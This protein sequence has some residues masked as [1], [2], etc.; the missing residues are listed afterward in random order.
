MIYFMDK[1]SIDSPD[2]KPGPATYFVQQ[3]AEVLSNFN[4]DMENGLSSETAKQLL[5]KNGPNEL[6]ANVTPKWVMFLRQFNNVI[7]YILLFAAAMTLLLQHYSDAIV[8]GLVVIINAFI[9]YFQEVNASNALEKIKSLLSTEATVIRDGNRTDIPAS[10]LVVGDIVYLEAGDNVPADLRLLDGDN[11]RIQESALTG[12]ADS[13]LKTFEPLTDNK[14][15]LA[16][17]TNMAY[18]STAVTNGSATG[19]VVQTGHDTELGQI[20]SDVS[21]VKAAKTPLMQ[22]LDGLGKWISYFIIAIAIILF[23]IGWWT[24]IYSLPILALAVVTM[25]VGSLPEGLPASTSVILAMGVNKMAKH[26]A[27]VKTLPAVETLGTVDVIAT[28]KTGTLTKNE[29]TAQDIIT[30]DHRY[31]VTGTGY[32]PEGQ[33]LLNQEAVKIAEDSTLQKLLVAG[34]EANDTMLQ[35]EDGQWIINGEPTDG[36]FLTLYH[37]GFG[38]DQ[39]ELTELDRIPF[40]SDYR[41]IARLDE[42]ADGQHEVFIKG[43]PDKLYQMALAADP[44]FDLKEWDDIIAELTHQGKR[45]VAVGHKLVDSD[46]D[47]VTH[48][49]LRQGVDFLGIVGIIDPPREEVISALKEMHTA[50]VEV[51]MITGD[52][53][54]TA[55]A[56]GRQLGLAD[57]I[58]TI[59]GAELDKMSPEELK[60]NI[61][62][63]NVFARTTPRNKLAIID[64][65]Q[66]NGKITAMTGDGVNDAPALKKADI[67][68][69]MGIKGT[70][71]AKDAADMILVDD[72]FTTMTKAIREGR[73]L[74]ANIKKTIV[75]LLPTSFAEGLIVAFSILMQQ[76]LPLVPTQL[77]WINM[78]SAITIQFAFIFEPEE[79]GIMQRP[80]RKTGTSLLN[81]RDVFQLTYVS[82]L[83]AAM[84]LWAFDWL[85]SSGVSHIVASTITVNVIIMGKIFYLFN[86]RTPHLAFGRHFFTNPMA[87]ATIG[88]LIV[89]QL[90]LVYL[91]FMQGVFKTGNMTLEQWGIAAAAGFVTL[92]VTELDKVIRIMINHKR[93]TKMA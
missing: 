87:F 91:P 11:L 17:R 31:Q 49:T 75:F 19:I 50:G 18:A 88:L 68:V 89:L 6:T 51:K 92:L 21:D 62:H 16:E 37:K 42:D 46:V 38:P 28:D 93:K 41:Y 1:R 27:I 29:M 58:N 55:A 63:Y 30:V 66:K 82:I 47:E 86:I 67:G 7:I 39:P 53:P 59:T 65:Y 45:V 33:I 10:Q 32:A 71:V 77:L 22:E 20:A 14:T 61:G 84:G 69:S 80:P 57:R 34:F 4:S 40:D 85:T 64:A 24:H 72:N 12:E 76:A 26:N 36:A 56:I 74:Y 90:L 44:T 54:D 48:E 79:E 35:Q 5:A 15:P 70:D 83:I 43:A 23:G 78:V 25:V 52:H 8:I 60:A 13:V 73:R 81:K 2:S 9:G 3:E